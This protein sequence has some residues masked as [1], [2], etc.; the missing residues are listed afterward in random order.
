M[1]QRRKAGSDSKSGGSSR[2]PSRDEGDRILGTAPSSPDI[3]KL[4][5]MEPSE[6]AKR[7]E[8]SPV[9]AMGHDKRRQ[10]VGH[11]YGPSRRSQVIFF[12]IVATIAVVLVG[13]GMAAVSA[14]DTIPDELPDE[15]PWSKPAATP[16]LQAQQQASPKS[17]DTPCGEPGN[18]YPAPSGSPCAPASASSAGE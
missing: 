13:G 12:V 17:V 2:S 5:L 7:H 3:R 15:A 6:E 4:E 9:D 8:A 1:A 18:E 11:S 10:V 16:E 14:F